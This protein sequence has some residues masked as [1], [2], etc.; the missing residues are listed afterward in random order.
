MKVFGK[1][2]VKELL[3]NNRKIYKA[4]IYKKSI[5]D[6]LINELEKREIKINYLEKYELDK[7]EKGNHQGIIV[8]I[9]DYETL[10]LNELLNK[11]ETPKP[12]IVMLDHITDPHNFGAIVR[13]CEAAGVDGII[14][15]KDRSVEVNATVMRVSVGALDNITIATV[16]NLV[17]AINTLKEKGYWIVGTDMNGKNYNEIDYD[18]PIC[19][20]IGNEGEGMSRLVHESCDYIGTIPM[21]GK[22]N[23]LNASV[24]SGIMIYKILESRK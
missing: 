18:S 21:N 12:I 5:D 23:S 13:T 10:S 19:L 17:M 2:I 3:N 14:I 8:D 1:N 4:Y 7:M 22:I 15:P 11:V 16:N 6:D 24:A 9:D 20:I